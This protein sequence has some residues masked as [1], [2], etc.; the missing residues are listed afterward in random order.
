MKHYAVVGKLFIVS[1]FTAFL[2]YGI[3]LGF[4]AYLQNYGQ[5][6]Y[7]QG[8]QSCRSETI[9]RKQKAPILS[10]DV[11]QEMDFAYLTSGYRDSTESGLYVG[12]VEA[13]R[14]D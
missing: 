11:T 8:Y 6:K 5:F 1:L 9:P 4:Q 13:E 7:L 14:S 3:H 2:T 12:L 10:T